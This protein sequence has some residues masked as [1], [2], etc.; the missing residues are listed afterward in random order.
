MDIDDVKAEWDKRFEDEKDGFK[1]AAIKN[2]T[3]IKKTQF[4]VPDITAFKEAYKIKKE[5]EQ[6]DLKDKY[7]AGASSVSVFVSG[8]VASPKGMTD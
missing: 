1:K 4:D 5:L 7:K 2:R 8:E 6:D 3:A